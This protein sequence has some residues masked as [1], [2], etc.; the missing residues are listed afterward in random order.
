[1]QNTVQN[2]WQ[3]QNYFSNPGNSF[4]GTFN[5]SF[6]G[7]G[8]GITGIPS[9]S[10]ANTWTGVNIFSNA[11]NTFVGNGAGLTNLNPANI[12]SGIFTSGI[13]LNLNGGTISNGIFSGGFTGTS[14]ILTG[15]FGVVGNSPPSVYYGDGS[16]LTGTAPSSISASIITAAQFQSGIFDGSAALGT[17]FGTGT[18]LIV[19]YGV[20]SGGTGVLTGTFGVPSNSPGSTYYGN[21]E[22]LLG[23]PQLAS[24]QTWTGANTFSN[25]SNSFTGDGTGLTGI[26][27][28]AATQ[29][30]TGVNSFVDY[31]KAN[32]NFAYVYGSETYQISMLSA[33]DIF[34]KGNI[35]AVG[36][37][38]ASGQLAAGENITSAQSIQAGYVSP[39]VYN[40]AY[41]YYGD[42]SN[43][44]GITSKCIEGSGGTLFASTG[45]VSGGNIVFSAEG[46]TL[47]FANGLLVGF[48][49]P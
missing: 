44:T 1:M 36:F 19:F 22:N 49:T 34:S 28:L 38:V 12:S 21:G 17:Q 2:T 24:T 6:V 35:E 48:T 42:A 27:Q 13:S 3:G 40:P 4:V 15:Q 30:W 45:G 25:A 32:G 9:W 7:S 47:T 43:V 29:A 37:I 8:S 26:P 18:H 46:F 14:N 33:N 23:I 39:G 5:G 31:I 16:Q 10:G 11:S 41:G 20:F